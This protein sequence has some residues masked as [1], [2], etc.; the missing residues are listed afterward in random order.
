MVRRLALAGPASQL[1]PGPDAE[2]GENVAQV[3]VHRVHGNV[4]PLGDLT[5]GNA[6]WVTSRTTANSEAVSSGHCAAAG[7]GRPGARCAP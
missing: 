6:P 1:D 2:L 5:V 4:E 3:R 7:S